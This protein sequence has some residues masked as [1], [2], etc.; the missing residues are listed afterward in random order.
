MYGE[1]GMVSQ[2]AA[3]AVEMELNQEQGSNQSRTIM[4]ELVLVKVLINKAAA[5]KIVQVHFLDLNMLTIK[6]LLLAF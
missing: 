5:P 3:R 4:E 2:F 6:I 1:V